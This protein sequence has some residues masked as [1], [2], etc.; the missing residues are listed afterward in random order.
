MKGYEEIDVD[1]PLKTVQEAF[2][3]AYK[4]AKSRG[5]GVLQRKE[6]ADRSDVFENVLMEGDYPGDPT[7]EPGEFNGDYVFGRMLKLTIR[8][9]DGSVY[10]PKS[11]VDPSYQSWASTYDSYRD[12][13]ECAKA[14]VAEMDP[15][16]IETLDSSTV[17]D[18]IKNMFS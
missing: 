14:K 9:Q 13:I 4:A 10:V 5:M 7:N 2:W 16:E 17:W 11:D 1:Y 15:N 6:D 3:L 8:I 12:L 18:K